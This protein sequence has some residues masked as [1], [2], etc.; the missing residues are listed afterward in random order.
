MQH[1]LSPLQ[2]WSHCLVPRPNRWIHLPMQ[3]QMICNPGTAEPA[4]TKKP[5]C[6]SCHSSSHREPDCPCNCCWV[7]KKHAP[8]HRVID[9]PQLPRNKQAIVKYDYP[10]HTRFKDI[11]GFQ[12][13][14]LN[15]ENWLYGPKNNSTDSTIAFINSTVFKLH[16]HSPLFVTA[17]YTM[18]MHPALHEIIHHS[19]YWLPEDLHIIV[20]NTAFH[21]HLYCFKWDSSIFKSWLTEGDNTPFH[22]SGTSIA[23]SFILDGISIE[24]LANFLWVFYNPTHSLYNTKTCA[25]WFGILQIV[26]HYVFDAV[27]ELCYRELS[28]LADQANSDTNW[29]TNGGPDRSVH[30]ASCSTIYDS[31]SNDA[32]PRP[33]QAAP[34]EHVTPQPPS[35][36]VV[37]VTPVWILHP[38]HPYSVDQNGLPYIMAHSTN[39][40]IGF[41]WGQGLHS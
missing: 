6:F 4:T 5:T 41:D 20:K 24:A 38:D 31:D 32:H 12:D 36:E 27:R 37:I 14:N 33:A 30:T 19:T 3:P 40:W 26:E 23:T 21:I 16:C 18:P 8:G 35:S 10:N 7:C 22:P 34:E 28:F 39:Q 9:F 1:L 13:G 25:Q 15:G 2:L 29:D 17:L 11:Y